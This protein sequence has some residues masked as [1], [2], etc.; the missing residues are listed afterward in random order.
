MNVSKFFVILIAGILTV[1]I[2]IGILWCVREL[3]LLLGT[4]STQATWITGVVWVLTLFLLD[5]IEG[6]KRRHIPTH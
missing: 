4:T 3:I 1:G 6:A 5:D 2:Y